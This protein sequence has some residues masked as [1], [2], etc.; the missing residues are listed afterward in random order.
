M[1]STILAN[2][3]IDE[4][5]KL[6]DKDF[7]I[8]NTDG[9]IVASSDEER[10]GQYH[11]GALL[12]VQE[13]RKV[14]ITQED[15]P[16]LKGVKAGVNLPIMFHGQ[17]IGVIGIT[18]D[19]ED[20]LPFGE[21][22]QKMTELFIRE[23]Y[24]SEQTQWRS[25]MIESLVLDWIQRKEWSPEFLERAHVL[26]VDLQMR[27]L[28]VFIQLDT[29]PAYIFDRLG[30][31]EFAWGEHTGNDLMIQWGNDRFL[32]LHGEQVLRKEDLYVKLHQVKTFMEQ[33]WKIPVSIG[34]G[35]IVDPQELGRGVACAEKALM[36][37]MKS[38]SIVFEEDLRL[39]LCLQEIGASTKEEFIRRVLQPIL[40][41][42]DLFVT[43]NALFANN[44][45]MKQTAKELHIHIN[46]LHYR[47]KKIEEFTKF[48]L[49]SVSNLFNLYL[50]LQFLDESTNIH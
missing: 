22:L 28:P 48:D 11:E 14:I 24:Y 18:G 29:E 10:I 4:V 49:K 34:V 12:C 7:I 43:L 17:V 44:L 8:V 23:S 2:K 37:A 13:R 1:L 31:L 46:T 32:L 45:S 41:Q 39:Q 50:A 16:K 35:A 9:E 38:N 40:N 3:I 27:R 26:K 33:S 21:L 25:R 5:K 42:K 47:L 20:T 30:Q 36:S 6:M 19:P 15:V